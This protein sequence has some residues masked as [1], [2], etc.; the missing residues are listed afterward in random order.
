MSKV[1]NV[2]FST[3]HTDCRQTRRLCM[4]EHTWQYGLSDRQ[5]SQVLQWLLR[6][7]SH[8]LQRLA[9]KAE[10]R[11][12]TLGLEVV[13]RYE[14]NVV[15]TATQAMELLADVNSAA[16][17]VHLDTYHMNIE[18]L[19][20][21]AAVRACRGKLGCVPSCTLNLRLHT[22]HGVAVQSVD[23][24]V[25]MCMQLLLP[26]GPSSWQCTCGRECAGA[27]EMYTHTRLRQ[28][29]HALNSHINERAAGTCT[30]ASRT[31]VT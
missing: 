22:C 6:Q 10:D 28:A 17:T 11:G 12:I 4:R 8:G 31:E 21:A 30:L 26:G 7:A 5:S 24:A 23:V 13:N 20:M 15:N 18:E 25:W 3:T 14:T 29:Q 19:S 9:A 16:V 27:R 2:G 1:S